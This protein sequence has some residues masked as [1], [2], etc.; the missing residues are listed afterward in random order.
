MQLTDHRCVRLRQ[1]VTGFGHRRRL[2]VVVGHEHHV[3]ASE[4]A[5]HEARNGQLQEVPQVLHLRLELGR[6]SFGASRVLAEVLDEPFVQHRGPRED[7][8]TEREEDG[9]DG[10]DE[11]PERDH[12]T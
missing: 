5:V 6:G 1:E 8:Q 11:V 3:L 2:G 12:G 10:H 4:L 7:A 9:D